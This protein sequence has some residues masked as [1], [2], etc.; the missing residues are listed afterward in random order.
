MMNE[1][2]FNPRDYGLEQQHET[3]YEPQLVAIKALISPG[4]ADQFIERYGRQS[5]E[6][7]SPEYFL[8]TIYVPQN[9]IGFQFL[10]SFG[11]NL[12]VIEPKAYVEEFRDFLNKMVEKYISKGSH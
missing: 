7:Y 3:G 9:S 11:T 6:D 10:A 4:I 8:A 2:T 5:I 12:E 1:S